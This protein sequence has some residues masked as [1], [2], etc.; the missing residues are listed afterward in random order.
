MTMKNMMRCRKHAAN[1][2]TRVIIDDANKSLW[3][4]PWINHKSLV[5]ILGWHRLAMFDTNKRVSH[6]IHNNKFC[7][8]MLPETRKAK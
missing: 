7:L 4:D 5:D 8:D 6:I 3:F 1:I 2:F